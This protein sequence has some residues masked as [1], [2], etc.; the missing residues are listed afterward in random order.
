MNPENLK[1][2]VEVSMPYGKYMGRV[3]A[4]LPVNYLNWFSAKGFPSGNLGKLLAL[5][6]ELDHNG[7]YLVP[8]REFVLVN[9]PL[10]WF[11]LNNQGGI[12]I[13]PFS[14]NPD[15]QNLTG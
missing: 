8:R 9:Q 7:F 11:F 3:I 15:Y 10:C 2:L 12:W 6:H 1:K 5:M 4:A 13:R 14:Y